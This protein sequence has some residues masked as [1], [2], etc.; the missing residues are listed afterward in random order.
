M[1]GKYSSALETY[2]RGLSIYE[3]EEGEKSCNVALTL[4][5]IGWVYYQRAE[6]DEAL[7]NYRRS[8]AIWE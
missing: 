3:K 7:I 5:N 4:Y 2:K 1:Q 6:Y 8:L